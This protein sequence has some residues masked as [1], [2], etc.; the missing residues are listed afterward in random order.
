MLLNMKDLLAVANEHNFAVP[1]FNIGTGQIL[2]AVVDCCEEKQAPV[3]LAIH[4]N[5]LEFQ[6][7]SFIEMCKD[8]ANKSHVPMCIHLDHGETMEQVQ[9][10]IRCGFTSVM[11]DA[12]GKAFEDNILITKEVIKVAHPLG[13]SVEAE[14]GTI[15]DIKED[16]GNREIGAKEI[17][18]TKPEDAEKF[19]KETNCD[20]LAIAIG[21]AHGI[22]PKDFVPHLEQEL[23]TEIKNRVSIPLVLHGGSANPD[24]EIAEAVKR[25]VNKINIS[26]DIKDA[27]YQ[28]TR[29]TLENDAVI[30]EP[31]DLYIDSILAMKKVVKQKIDLFNDADKMKYYKL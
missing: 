28:Q 27:F 20:T 10:A 1:A 12:S 5:E 18:F 22:Y 6:G 9:R 14:L 25:G 31:F 3:I 16:S 15:G 4:P 11:I 30:R 23:L 13:V 21:T 26:S 7:D 8:R 2:N 19:I 29:K 17:V 24:S